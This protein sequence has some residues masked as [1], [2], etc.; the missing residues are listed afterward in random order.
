MFHSY[1]IGAGKRMT[2]ISNIQVCLRITRRTSTKN[3]KKRWFQTWLAISPSQNGGDSIRDRPGEKV[4]GSFFPEE[5]GKVVVH[6]LD[7]YFLEPNLVQ[8]FS[9]FR[10]FHG[11]FSQN[12]S[13]FFEDG[14]SWSFF[15]GVAKDWYYQMSWGK[16]PQKPIISHTERQR[17]SRRSFAYEQRPLRWEK[18]REAKTGAYFRARQKQQVELGTK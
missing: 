1:L 18:R 3:T 6:D 17:Q 4:L 13:C 5:K 2:S 16:L 8:G 9:N 11:K 15:W 14:I 12:P 10:N 7:V